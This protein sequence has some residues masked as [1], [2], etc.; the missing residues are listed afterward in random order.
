MRMLLI[1]P[2]IFGI[3]L[4]LSNDDDDAGGQLATNL[5]P[6]IIPSGGDSND[7]DYND[8]ALYGH[9]PPQSGGQQA[10]GAGQ[11]GGGNPGAA[12][13]GDSSNS[14][15]Q[16]DQAVGANQNAVGGGNPGAA[17]AGDS[18]NSVD[19]AGTGA[20]VKSPA[21]QLANAARAV[22]V[23]VGVIAVGAMSAFTLSVA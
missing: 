21:A 2:A 18:S 20:A 5:N 19:Q 16:V 1:L 9:V 3:A 22:G 13:A 23:V 8:K 17:G 11:I 4:S 6:P 15:D 14:V 7:Q 10:A 12:G